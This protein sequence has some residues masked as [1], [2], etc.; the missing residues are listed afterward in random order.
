MNFPSSGGYSSNITE[1]TGGIYTQGFRGCIL[2][3]M[4]SLTAGPWYEV[5]M[6]TQA[7]AGGSIGACEAEVC[8]LLPSGDVCLNQGTCVQTGAS[9]SC[10][11]P[12]PYYGA[13]CLKR[14]S[15]S[16]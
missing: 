14:K 7:L 5:N 10:L 12:I 2:G 11:C 4:G 16:D 15:K 8:S 6:Q 9:T 13:T 1:L 3:L